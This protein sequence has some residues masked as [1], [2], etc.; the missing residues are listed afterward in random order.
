TI[1]LR[2][3]QMVEQVLDMTCGQLGAGIPLEERTDQDLA[4]I[5]T[6]LVEEVREALPRRPLDLVVRRPCSVSID[7]MLIEQ[8]LRTNIGKA[9]TYGSGDRPVRV[10]VDV[11]DQT[12]R[13]EVQGPGSPVDEES[14]GLGLSF[15]LAQRIVAAHEGELAVALTADD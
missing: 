7:R 8:V 12:A 5:L 1:G 15:Y 3:K 10:V 11:S 4:A 2:M 13:I 14:A 9:L 6:A